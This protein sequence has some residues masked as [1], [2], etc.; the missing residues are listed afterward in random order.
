M[1]S[2]VKKLILACTIIVIVSCA[3]P[4]N[5]LR[6]IADISEN[7]N[8]INS[9]TGNSSYESN[10]TYNR[11]AIGDLHFITDDDYFYSEE[12]FESGWMY[13]RIGKMLQSPAIDT[14]NMAK[15]MDVVTGNESWTENVWQTRLATSSDIKLGKIV[16]IFDRIE[17]NDLYCKP[18]DSEEARTGSWYMAKI[19]DTSDLFQNAVMVSG[20][21]KVKTDNLRVIK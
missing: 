5:A 12:K 3:G 17:G 20:G 7:V 18:V 21:Y 6:N 15:V 1:K 19:T 8:R 10:G 13:V 14:K 4:A 2:T 11:M 16:I 9:N